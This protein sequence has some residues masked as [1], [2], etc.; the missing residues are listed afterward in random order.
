MPNPTHSLTTQEKLLGMDER[1]TRRDFCNAGLLAAGAILLETSAPLRLWAANDPWDGYGGV[2]DYATS[3][4]NTADVVRAAHQIRDGLFD[5]PP[6]KAIDTGEVFD[7]VVIGGGLS[8]LSAAYHFKKAKKGGTCLVIENHPI[9]GGESK[10]NEFIVGGQRLMGPQ[11]ANEFDIPIDPKE[12]GYEL[13][14]ELGIP[15]T[16]SYQTWDNQLGRLDFDR[17]NYGFQIWLDSPSFGFFFDSPSSPSKAVKKS[18]PRPLGSGPSDPAMQG[19]RL[20][21]AGSEFSHS[22]SAGR[23]IRDLWGKRLQD[24]PYP[25]RVRSDLLTWR[26]GTKRRER[27]ADFERW[28]DSMTYKDFLEKFLGLDPAVTGYADPIL[29]AAVGL[30]CDVISAYAAYQIGV[31][32]F[33]GFTKNSSPPRSPDEVPSHTWHMFPGGNTGFARYFVK[34]LI[35][36]AISGRHTL[37]EILN[38]RVNFKALDQL[39]SNIRIRLGATAVRVEHEGMPERAQFVMVTYTRGGK[40]YRLKARSVVMAG[41]GWST[42]RVVR[43]LPEEY[44]N[45]YSQFHH[46][47]MLV[48]NVAVT[49][50][51]FLYKLG[52]TAAR[53]FDGFAF[54]CNLR[55]QML[56]G[57]YQPKLHPDFPNIITFYIP[58]YYPGL[59]IAD[60][61]ARGQTELL[62]TSYREY[63]R[64]IRGQMLRLFGGAGFNPRKDIAGIILNR[65]GHAFV[66]PQPGFYFGK[67]GRPAPRDIIRRPFGRIAFAHSELVGHQY[68]LGAIGE[69]RR[70]ATQLAL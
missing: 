21:R 15:R 36:A 42:R 20:R 60:Q 50:W 56:V 39:G 31:P 69:G 45:A 8:G 64:Q 9:F 27:P 67:D 33:Q 10:Q 12:D 38:D 26:Y 44:R 37:E 14:G 28:L 32:G 63:E 47:P 40:V 22:L 57:E 18:E 2:G 55:R 52:I 3:H 43:D 53:W 34:A 41:G 51:R 48:V 70:A 5:R 1:I 49:N 29:A 19:P 54:S 11:G 7:C 6:V 25:E 59:D 30:G 58:F 24:S 62:S 16:F 65:W 61:C 23:C 46:S 17:T 35:P 66:D 4:G 13:Y 68:W